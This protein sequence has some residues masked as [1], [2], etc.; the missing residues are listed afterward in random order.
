MTLLVIWRVIVIMETITLH[1]LYQAT[2]QP[3][4]LK[5]T[6]Y[7]PTEDEYVLAVYYFYLQN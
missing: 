3:Y 5:K 1:F 2:F 4:L 7:I 6:R